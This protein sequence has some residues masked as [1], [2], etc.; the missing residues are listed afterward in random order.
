MHGRRAASYSCFPG[1]S[2]IVSTSTF[3]SRQTESRVKLF[4]LHARK[5]THKFPRINAIAAC[6]KREKSQLPYNLLSRPTQPFSP[7]H[8]ASG[9]TCLMASQM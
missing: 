1:L 9:Q 7:G 4:M 6:T 3:S 8:L 5:A 2:D